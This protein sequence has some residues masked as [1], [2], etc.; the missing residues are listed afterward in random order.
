M[1]IISR[2]EM[3]MTVILDDN[4]F[5]EV[6]SLKNNND[7]IVL[8]CVNSVIHIDEIPIHKINEKIL[9][10]KETKKIKKYLNYNNIE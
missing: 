2:D 7:K 4:D 8:K 1:K 9:D 6:I 5:L 10:E 3:H